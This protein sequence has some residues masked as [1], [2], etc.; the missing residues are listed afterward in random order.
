[1]FEHG[2]GKAIGNGEE[3]ICNGLDAL[4]GIPIKFRQVRIN[5]RHYNLHTQPEILNI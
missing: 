3:L 1:M 5:S 4:G 2:S